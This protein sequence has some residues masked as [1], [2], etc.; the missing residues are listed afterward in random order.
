MTAELPRNFD[1]Q[2]A[3]WL[4]AVKVWYSKHEIGDRLEYRMPRDQRFVPGG[5]RWQVL[6]GNGGTRRL[7]RNIRKAVAETKRC[8][9]QKS[10]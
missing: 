4:Y 2:W 6:E 3:E 1:R 5:N 9:I 10:S 8:E 7:Q